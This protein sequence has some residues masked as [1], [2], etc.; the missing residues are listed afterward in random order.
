MSKSGD[1]VAL[2]VR[3]EPLALTPRYNIAPSQEA[4]VILA[5][6]APEMKLLRWGL[7]PP[8]AKNESIGARHINARAETVCDKPAFRNAFAGQRCLVLADGYY[9]WKGKRPY[10]FALKEETPFAFA[11]LWEKWSTADAPP[12]LT[13][14]IITTEP[15]ELA[16]K[17]HDRMP[18][19]LRAEDYEKWLDPDFRDQEALKGI[20]VPCP[21]AE[22]ISYPVVSMVNNPKCDDPRCIERYEESGLLP[23]FED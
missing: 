13:F 11:G 23:G 16:R 21:A 8:W 3:V 1:G 6:T 18:V 4:P 9:E 7:V 17:A 12:L 19:I 22:M 10:R 2:R 15:N 20:L 5:N 14:T